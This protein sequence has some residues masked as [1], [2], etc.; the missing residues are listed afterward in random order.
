MANPHVYV[1][2]WAPMFTV[3]AR[4]LE[5]DRPQS[6]RSEKRRTT[7]TNHPPTS[8]FQLLGVFL[9]GGP[10]NGGGWPRGVERGTHE[11]RK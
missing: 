8:M 11:G 5:D 9:R 10:P 3:G 7:G 1:V 2:L 6:Q 4:K